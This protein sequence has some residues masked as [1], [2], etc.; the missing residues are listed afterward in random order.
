MRRTFFFC[1]AIAV[2]IAVAGCATQPAP[3]AYHPPGF[4][5]GLLHGFTVFFSLI[6]GLF[7]DVRIYAFPNSGWF[8]DLGFF[9]GFGS[10]AGL[11]IAAR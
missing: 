6:G 10:W 5:Y 9:L 3:S 11:P 1:W 4:L 8:Y 2:C 7:W